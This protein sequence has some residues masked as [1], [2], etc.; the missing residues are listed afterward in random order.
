MAYSRPVLAGADDF[1]AFVSIALRHATSGKLGAAPAVESQAKSLHPG[2][3]LRLPVA[4]ANAAT[5]DAMRIGRRKFANTTR[6]TAKE[7][8]DLT[9]KSQRADER[10]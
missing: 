10:D 2:Q 4:N 1:I 9:S 7:L 6:L 5:G 8:G 3:R